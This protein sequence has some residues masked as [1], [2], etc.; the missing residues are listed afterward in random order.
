[1]CLR[2]DRFAIRAVFSY[3]T[4]RVNLLARRYCGEQT[5]PCPCSVLLLLETS[6]ELMKRGVLA[7]HWRRKG[8]V[9][10]P[11]F[12]WDGKKWDWKTVG[13]YPGLKATPPLQS[14]PV[15]KWVIS[16]LDS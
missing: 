16:V 8:K 12:S 5:G 14:P 9:V 4:S 13:S 11:S 3:C 2:K 1:M 7:L 10:R 15:E 6:A